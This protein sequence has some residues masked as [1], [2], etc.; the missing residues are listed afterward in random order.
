VTGPILFARSTLESIVDVCRLHASE[1]VCGI[2]WSEADG[3]LDR[4]V[5]IPNVAH[6][7][8]LEFRFDPACQLSMW[9]ALE[10]RGLKPSLVWHS[11]RQFSPLPSQLDVLNVTEPAV[12]LIVGRVHLPTP[13]V[14]VW[15][16][17][18]GLPGGYR[19][20]PHKVV[21]WAK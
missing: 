13:S 14:L 12:H 2:A 17:D 4:M 7:R 19:V 11:H 18:A 1:E 15:T 3:V 10:Q 21:E 8:E 5:V 9:N 6:E 16:A 20:L